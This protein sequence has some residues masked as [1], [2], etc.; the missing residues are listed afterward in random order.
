MVMGLHLESYGRIFLNLGVKFQTSFS[1]IIVN[2][3]HDGIGGTIKRS[4]YQVVQQNK[5]VI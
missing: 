1:H 3:A 4:V 2:G 5:F